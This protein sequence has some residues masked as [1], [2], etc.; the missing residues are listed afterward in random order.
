MPWHLPQTVF[1]TGFFGDLG[2][3]LAFGFFVVCKGVVWWMEGGGG[4]GA[5]CCFVVNGVVE[6]NGK[7]G[8]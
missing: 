3:F 5:G 1:G 2:V 4:E 6:G 7:G 8:D